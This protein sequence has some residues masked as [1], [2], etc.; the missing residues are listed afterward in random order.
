MK[1]AFFFA[2]TLSGETDWGVI[3]PLV[4]AAHYS[5][6]LE[7]QASLQIKLIVATLQLN[8]GFL[9]SAPWAIMGQLSL[10]KEQ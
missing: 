6:H 8:Y 9:F 4:P 5:V 7:E 3:L 1:V 2:F 10:A